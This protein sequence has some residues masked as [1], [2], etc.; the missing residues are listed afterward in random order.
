M[1]NRQEVQEL[2]L[3][4]VMGDRFD[5]IPNILSKNVHCLISVMD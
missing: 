1:E 2:T 5:V 3:E 4:E